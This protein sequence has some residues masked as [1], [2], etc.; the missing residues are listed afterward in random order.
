VLA[1]SVAGWAGGYGAEAFGYADFFVLTFFLGLPAYLLLP[2]VKKMLA[3]M[4]SVQ[5]ETSRA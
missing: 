5:P 2:W 4:E 1:R 3:D